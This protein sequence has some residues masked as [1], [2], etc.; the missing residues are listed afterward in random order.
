MQPHR[1]SSADSSANSRNTDEDIR[2]DS[3]VIARVGGL[4]GAFPGFFYLSPSPR[5]NCEF[6]HGRKGGNIA[7]P[8][9]H[10]GDGPQ[11]SGFEDTPPSTK[12]P[13]P[14]LR[15]VAV[16]L[17]TRYV[18]PAKSVRW[19]ERTASLPPHS[20]ASRSTIRPHK[21]GV[22]AACST[23]PTFPW[24]GFTCPHPTPVE[25][26]TGMIIPFLLI[27]QPGTGFC[28]RISRMHP[29]SVPPSVGRKR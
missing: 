20:C 10:V 28:P 19:R 24:L 27:R 9:F 8:S 12:Y 11:S 2:T 18:R 25:T 5:D 7:H 15:S 1:L 21:R 6:C 16:V 3:L 14:C 22:K 23:H 13:P 29:E 4:R 26:S 17:A